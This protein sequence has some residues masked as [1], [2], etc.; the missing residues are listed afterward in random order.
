MLSGPGTMTVGA[1]GH[2]GGGGEGSKL[3]RIFYRMLGRTTRGLGVLARRG[4]RLEVPCR[5]LFGR[6]PGKRLL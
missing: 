6:V 4:A 2:S 1:G 5:Q 3:G